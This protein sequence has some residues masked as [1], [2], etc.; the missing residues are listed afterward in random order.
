MKKFLLFSMAALMTMALACKKDNKPEEETPFI[1]QTAQDFAGTVWVSKTGSPENSAVTAII[2]FSKDGARTYFINPETH[3]VYRIYHDEYSFT[4]KQIQIGMSGLELSPEPQFDLTV[5]FNYGGDVDGE[6][7]ALYLVSKDGTVIPD[8]P[9]IYALQKKCNLG[10]LLQ[11]YYYP[12]AID[13]GMV[14]DGKK[15][16]WASCNLGASKEHECGD[17]YA[18]GET[19]TKDSNDSQG[20][21]SWETY[22]W[23]QN[24]QSDWKHVTKYTFADRETEGIWYEGDTFKGDDGDGVEHKDFA[25]YDY[26][27]DAARA[28]LG[29]GWHTP[30]YAE[31]DWLRK[32]CTW[33][34]T[35]NYNGTKV[36]GSVV[37]SG[38]NGNVIFLPAAG[39]RDYTSRSGYLSKG[40]YWSADL[41]DST[42]LKY[43]YRGRSIYFYLYSG[44]VY[45]LSHEQDRFNGLS[46]R[47]VRVE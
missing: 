12:M 13:L 44:E 31:W 46:I 32:N 35:D 41:Y 43:S 9:M 10:A 1:P 18:W 22:K 2:A 7:M 36:K 30:T 47:P 3:R 29:A 26:A 37:T 11:E 16:L 40:Y 5:L 8:D 39:F 42:T 25:S 27:D 23:M 4:D 45:S 21:Y 14:V 17:Y 19:E 33:T 20:N 28:N 38:I 24:G 15:I 34:W 6:T